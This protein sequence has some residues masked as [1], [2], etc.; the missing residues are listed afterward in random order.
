MS[1]AESPPSRAFRTTS[2]PALPRTRLIDPREEIPSPANRRLMGRRG[3]DT[4]GTYPAAH[5]LVEHCLPLHPRLALVQGWLIDPAQQIVCLRA[6]GQV[7]APEAE[8][9]TL[10]PSPCTHTRLDVDAGLRTHYAQSGHSLADGTAMGFCTLVPLAPACVTVSLQAQRV[11]GPPL[12]WEL[13]VCDNPQALQTLLTPHML[14][15][16]LLPALGDLLHDDELRTDLAPLLAR[17]PPEVMTITPTPARLKIEHAVRIGPGL[18]IAG[19][20]FDA[21]G[22]PTPGG[23]LVQAQAAGAP[24]LMA[25]TSRMS[26]PD[27][28]ASLSQERHLP[29]PNVGFIAWLPDTQNSPTATSWR[30]WHLDGQGGLAG[31]VAEVTPDTDPDVAAR[32]LHLVPV[33]APHMRQLYDQHLGPALEQW[34]SRQRRTLPP[35]V[36][37]LQF[38]PVVADPRVSLII[39]LYGRWDF[40][41]Y[42]LALFRQDPEL[43]QHE[44][45]Y[46]VDD[47]SIHDAIVDY[48]RSTWPLYE[49]PFTLAYA[50]ENLGFAGA[51]NAAISVARGQHVLLLN[52]DI[53]PT[54]PGWLGRLREVLAS[55]PEVGMVGPA[56]LYSDESVQHAG[57]VFERYPHW[58]GLWTNLHPGKGWPASWML[59]GPPREVQALTGACVLM[60]RALYLRVGGLDE[61]YIRG[62]F[63]DSDL[64]LKVRALGLKPYLVPD[65]RLYHLERQSQGLRAQVTTRMLLTLFNCWRHSRRWDEAITRLTLE[66]PA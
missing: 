34:F 56:L 10:A 16:W 49:V 12:S 36:Q 6:T 54:A 59:D 28:V 62:D 20:S 1:H 64:C 18:F 21:H 7:P 63:E 24:L 22:R 53:I 52:S 9:V 66:L 61:G 31:C 26:R 8:R 48:W 51:N 3:A 50:G 25:A 33:T 13:P 39:P 27:V 44:L 42:Q 43:R 45:I 2:G 29:D 30:F 5:L 55:Q 60:E 41:E 46:F 57:M 23:L 38:G 19:W 65:A 35:Q 15:S 32:L 11:A 47:P 40:I 37:T 58:G 17:V 14:Q 4:A